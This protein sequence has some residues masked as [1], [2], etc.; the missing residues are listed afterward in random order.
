MPLTQKVNLA[1]FGDDSQA[2][3]ARTALF[4]FAMRVLAAALAF[5]LQV[6]FAR[7]MGAY[8]FGVYAVVWVW[9]LVLATFSG[10]GYSTG[11]LRFVPEL[12]GQ[13]RFA[14][15]RMVIWRGPLVSVG[16]CTVLALAAIAFILS[17]PHLVYSAYVIPVV[18]GAICLP[19]LT[20]VDSQEGIAQSFGWADLVTVPTFVVRPLVILMIFLG[21]SFSGVEPSA[22]LA[23]TATVIGIWLVSVTQLFILRRRVIARIGK[24]ALEGKVVPWVK[25]AIPM[26]I[27][28]GFFFLTLNT[29]I[30]IASLFVSPDQVAIYFAAGKTLALV[31]FVFYAIRVATSHKIA[32]FHASGDRAALERTLANTLHWTFWPSLA[33]GLIL[34][35]EGRLILSIFG[36]DFENGLPYLAILL[37][38][39]VIR[40]SVGPAQMMLTMAGAQKTAAR[41][42]GLV[43][44]IN[45][46]LNFALIP[47]MGLTGAAIATATAM[48]TEA[49][50][51]VLAVRRHL[52]VTSFI[53]LVRRLDNAA[54]QDSEPQHISQEP[55]QAAEP[56]AGAAK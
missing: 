23:M 3:A 17:F 11:L 39:T 2:L 40:A 1:V 52:G 7:M 38:G 50:L 16:L 36:E 24:G 6:L 34:L 9:V 33:I 55:K 26:V 22:V 48:A 27:V 46:A 13:Q 45:A 42:Y 37:V 21:L 35:V 28:D 44:L 41:L 29:D 54:P 5:G 53:G 47:S 19:M 15:L 18:L 51:L 14:E 31:H 49:V 4:T 32:Q 20:L 12:L 43:F 10:L 56:A 25:A 8:E 30:I